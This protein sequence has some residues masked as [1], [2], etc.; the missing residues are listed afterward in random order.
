MVE[1]GDIVVLDFPF[2]DGR[3]SKVRPALVVQNDADN[4]RLPKTIVAMITGNLRR[5]QE[6]THLLIDPATSEG[7]SSG[8]TGPSLAVFVNL[9]TVDQSAILR[10]LGHLTGK[11]LNQA[12]ACIRVSLD[13]QQA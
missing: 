12:D 3:Q 10:K 9:F 6:S 4:R 1:R 8:L 5:A 13:L 2:S 7:A 11:Q